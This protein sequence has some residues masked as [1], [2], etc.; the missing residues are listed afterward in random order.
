[1]IITSTPEAHLAAKVLDLAEEREEGGDLHQRVHGH[2]VHRI[3]HGL[4]SRTRG[5][6]YLSYAERITYLLK[7]MYISKR[8]KYVLKIS[9]KIVR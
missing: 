5:Q 3:A 6:C 8:I 7:A 1:V 9:K 2:R 4:R